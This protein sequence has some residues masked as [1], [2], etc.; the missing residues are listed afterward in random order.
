MNLSIYKPGGISISE[1]EISVIVRS[2]MASQNQN[3]KAGDRSAL[4]QAGRDIYVGITASEGRQ[5]AL[6]VF[7]AN[8]LELAGLAKELFEARATAFIERYLEELQRRRP[9]AVRSFAQPDMQY[10][11]FSAQREAAKSGDQEL[12]E[13]LTDILVDRAAEDSRNLKRIVLD[14]A[15][16]VAPKLTAKETSLLSLS[17]LLAKVSSVCKPWGV[18]DLH[19]GGSCSFFRRPPRELVFVL[20]LALHRLRIPD[21]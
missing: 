17:F 7:K 9:G 14:E 4:I 12:S 16:D 10:A 6:D 21:G 19:R 15:L 11:V 1:N 3:Q 8:A 2:G 18:A 5:I 13:L 20:S